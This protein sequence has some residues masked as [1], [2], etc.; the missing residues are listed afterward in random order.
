M[1]DVNTASAPMKIRSLFT[2]TCDVHSDN[3]RSSTS[4][5]FYI[6][7]SKLEVQRNAFS[8][9]G[10]SVRDTMYSQR[11]TKK[12]FQSKYAEQRKCLS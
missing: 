3:I 4:S 12:V 10:V 11:A 9:I 6:N 2:K 7:A 5:N 8:R 1:H